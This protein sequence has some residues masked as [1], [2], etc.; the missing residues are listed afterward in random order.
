LEVCRGTERL[1]SADAIGIKLERSRLKD[2]GNVRYRLMHV[3][4]ATA[5]S[6]LVVD[7]NFKDSLDPMHGC[8][9]ERARLS[10]G[11]IAI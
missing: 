5:D 11:Y 6:T 2:M 1:R 4:M 10:T 3:T 7:W 8:K 9:D